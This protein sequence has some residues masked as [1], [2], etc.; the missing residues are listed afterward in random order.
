M[1]SVI[2][3]SSEYSSTLQCF[4][5]RM[6]SFGIAYE[7][8]LDLLMTLNK[9]KTNR[10][11][12]LQITVCVSKNLIY[13]IPLSSKN[14][15]VSRA[16]VYV[17]C[18]IHRPAAINTA[19]INSSPQNAYSFLLFN[20]KPVLVAHWGGRSS[21][22]DSTTAQYL[23]F[24]LCSDHFNTSDWPWANQSNDNQQLIIKQAADWLCVKMCCAMCVR[25]FYW[26]LLSMCFQKIS[27]EWE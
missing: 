16:V 13:L 6:T 11:L 7:F 20:P 23:S 9:S 18:Y 4:T 21:F 10:D 3:T 26:F 15:S 17:E 8:N 25:Y 2:Q 12:I 14:T 24:K 19:T 22:V 27:W 5:V 1:I